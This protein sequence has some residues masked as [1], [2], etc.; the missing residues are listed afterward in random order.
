MLIRRMILFFILIALLISTFNARAAEDILSVDKTLIIQIIIF[1]AAIFIL[2]SLL[3]KPLLELVVRREKLTTG[4]IEEANQLGK[5][6]EQIINEYN[7]KLNEA[8]TQA[9]EERNEIRRQAQSAYDD[10]VKKAKEEAQTLLEEAKAKLQ[11]ET[12]EIKEKVR[13]D[14][15]VLA[16]EMASRILGKEV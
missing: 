7:V 15:E 4:T 6:V 9:M 16:R 14:I 8:R 10:I 13:S 2:N 3:F 1:V 11:S 5:K 12:K